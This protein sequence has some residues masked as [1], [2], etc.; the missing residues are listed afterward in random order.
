MLDRWS[1]CLCVSLSWPPHSKY[2]ILPAHS[3]GGQYQ[4]PQRG[5]LAVNGHS[6]ESAFLPLSLWGPVKNAFAHFTWSQTI[7][8]GFMDR[9]PRPTYS[10]GWAAGGF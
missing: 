6:G 5:S 3:R 1:S 10:G 9:S 7:H 2:V 8:H 4:T